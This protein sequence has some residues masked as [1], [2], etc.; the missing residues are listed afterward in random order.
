MRSSAIL[1]TLATAGLLAACGQKGPLYLPEPAPSTPHADGS[2]APS[3]DIGKRDDE[4]GTSWAD[5]SRDDAPASQGTDAEVGDGS[6]TQERSSNDTDAA[7]ERGTT[8]T[9][10]E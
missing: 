6:P 9:P 10:A 2:F 7:D 4:A 1:I 3:D 8:R 5:D